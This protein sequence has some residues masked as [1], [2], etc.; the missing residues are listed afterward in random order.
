MSAKTTADGREERGGEDPLAE[1]GPLEGVNVSA[2]TAAAVG[3]IAE[4]A[5]FDVTYRNHYKVGDQPEE[6]LHGL[7]RMLVRAPEGRVM[8]VA[9]D[10]IG[11]VMVAVDSGEHRTTVRPQPE[12]GWGCNPDAS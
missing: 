5:G 6:R 11:R 10:S 2:L 1:G 12:M 8:A 7:R 9:Y 4:D 3:G